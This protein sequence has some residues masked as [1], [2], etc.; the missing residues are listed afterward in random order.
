MT[1]GIS[2]TRADYTVLLVSSGRY[3][4]GPVGD[5]RRGYLRRIPGGSWAPADPSVRESGVPERVLGGRPITGHRR[6]S[7]RGL[8]RSRG[9]SRRSEKGRVHGE[10]EG[11]T[12][13]RSDGRVVLWTLSGG[14]VSSDAVSVVVLGEKRAPL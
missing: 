6:L 7:D 12:C 1:P 11:S 13:H 10:T 8:C 3:S 9:S 2:N 5:V 4:S 14:G